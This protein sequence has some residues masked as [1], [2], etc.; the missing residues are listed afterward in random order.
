[1]RVHVERLL[2]EYDMLAAFGAGPAAASVPF[3]CY[4]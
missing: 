1:L 4:D 3:S 2:Y